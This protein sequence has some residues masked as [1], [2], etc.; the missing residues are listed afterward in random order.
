MFLE[1]RRTIV[2]A[3]DRNKGHKTRLDADHLVILETSETLLKDGH[4]RGHGL[5]V[6]GA[7][8]HHAG[9]QGQ[10]VSTGGCPWPRP[11]QG[12]P[13]KAI[14]MAGLACRGQPAGVCLASQGPPGGAPLP[15]RAGVPGSCLVHMPSEPSGS[16]SLRAR[17]MG[18]APGF[19]VRHPGMTHNG[20]GAHLGCLGYELSAVV[21]ASTWPAALLA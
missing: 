17:S 12:S 15:P 3:N 16:V 10:P 18:I 21:P 11:R 20:S 6:Q 1:A 5:N 9:D 4:G 14:V 2:P 19:G 7:G 8:D 13:N